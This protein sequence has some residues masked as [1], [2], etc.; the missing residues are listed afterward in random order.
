MTC[1]L[2]AKSYSQTKMKKKM[3]RETEKK[4]MFLILG[5][6]LIISGSLVWKYGIYPD[7][8]FG[9][10]LCIGMGIG[11][12]FLWSFINEKNKR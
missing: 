11:M 9:S 12:I 8:L 3:K 2:A 4:W 7:S 5:I 10:G 6:T 1:Y